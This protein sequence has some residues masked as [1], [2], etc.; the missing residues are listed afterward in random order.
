M[1]IYILIIKTIEKINK[2]L[3][4]QRKIISAGECRQFLKKLRIPKYNIGGMEC[5]KA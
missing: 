2:T 5:A 3:Y 4:I 1:K